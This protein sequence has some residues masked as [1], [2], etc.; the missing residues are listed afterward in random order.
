MND[1]QWPRYQVF[2]QMSEGQPHVNAGTVH[3]P[4]GELALLNARDVFVRRPKCFNMWVVPAQVIYSKTIEE[5]MQAPNWAVQASQTERHP[6]EKYC[7][8]Q[9]TNHKGSHTYIGAL[10]ARSPEQAL[11]KALET[12]ANDKTLVWWVFPARFITQS[13]PDDVESMFAPAHD[14]FYR[15]QG[16][17]HTVAE[18]RKIK[19]SGNS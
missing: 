16:S 8:F 7:V 17:Y 3:A 19:R 2:Q 9:K 15:D 10:E 18:M 13:E 11:A 5:L 4:D 1:T 6:P 14:K 12:F